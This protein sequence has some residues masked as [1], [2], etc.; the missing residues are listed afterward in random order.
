VTELQWTLVLAT[1]KD[2]HVF[3]L[4]L[5]S[6]YF[7]AVYIVHAGLLDFESGSGMSDIWSFLANVAKCG[8][9]KI[10]VEI[11]GFGRFST[12]NTA[13]MHVDCEY[14]Y[15]EVMK[16]SDLTVCCTLNDCVLN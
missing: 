11:S 4:F 6:V 5:N 13:L 12:F 15:L 7:F 1:D 9:G 3:C 16:V 10:L 14:S 8:C 2:V